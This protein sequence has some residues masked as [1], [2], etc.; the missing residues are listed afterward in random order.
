MEND[1]VNE[2]LASLNRELDEVRGRIL[3]QKPLPSLKKLFSEVR[4]GEGRRK[5]MMNENC[6][7]YSK[8]TFSRARS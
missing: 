8:N 4:D 1:K 5:V 2:F 7:Y 3:G 6:C